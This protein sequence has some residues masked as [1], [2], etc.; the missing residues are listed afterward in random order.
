MQFKVVAGMVSALS[1]QAKR[2]KTKCVTLLDGVGGG[3]PLRISNALSRTNLA[4][5]L[6]IFKP[7]ER[8]LK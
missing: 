7:D 6:C 2:R 1:F 3:E 4:N 8:C 5:T